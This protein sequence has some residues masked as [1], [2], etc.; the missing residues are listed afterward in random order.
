MLEK[1]IF[2]PRTPT[3]IEAEV[4]QLRDEVVR[5]ASENADL[6][7]TN[8]D[9]RAVNATLKNDVTVAVSLG[10][11][12]KQQLAELKARLGTNSRNSSKPPSSDGPSVPPRK[13]RGGK[14]KRKPG[15]Q[16]G[17]A[18]TTRALMDVDEA[19]THEV[20]P[21]V[22]EQCQ[23][24][25]SGDDPEPE[26]RQVIDIP[27]PTLLVEEYHLHALTC[28][29]CGHATRAAMPAGAA[30]G[31]SPFG[32]RLHALCGLLVGRSKQCKRGVVELFSILYGLSI[33]VGS[34]S[35][36]ERRLSEAVA[37]PVEETRWH[38]RLA[39]WLHMDETSWRQRH[40]RAWLWL[41]ATREVAVFWINR[42]RGGPIVEEILGS[43]FT[44]A[45]CVD[46]WSA[47]GGIASRQ[48]CW[49]HLLRDFIA[50]I[51]RHHSAW[52]GRRLVQ[53]ACDVM[54]LWARHQA[55][56][57]DRVTLQAEAEPLRAKMHDLLAWTAANAPGRK[58][59]VMA[60]E[61]LKLEEHLWTFLSVEGLAP[62]NNHAERLLRYAVIWRKLSFG[63]QSEAGRLYVERLLTVTA[64]LTL[65]K[66]NVFDYLCEAMVAY[67]HGQPAA[68]ILPSTQATT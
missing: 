16:P 13:P 48:L 50:M 41:T 55:G 20:R 52:H 4:A 31:K 11:N 12:L 40:N 9:L 58:A 33:S 66:R 23:A 3:G 32:P 27:E 5:L 42:R 35:A 59:R 22:C 53:V 64:T 47:Y 21:E 45:L 38:I 44:G 29:A 18:G 17:H 39:E 10:E 62:T 30:I 7:T 67:S 37:A 63:T 26:R 43:A 14:G 51:Q 56:E 57:I 34:V 54:D 1:L 61:I 19:H 6:R 15:G 2:R 46:R 68:S 25:L 60:S 24:P 65:Q 36:M 8:A 49:A 28:G